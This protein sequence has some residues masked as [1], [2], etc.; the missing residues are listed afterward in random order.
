MST[1]NVQL[2]EGWSQFHGPNL[3]YVLEMYDLYTED[4]EA[5]DGELRQFFEKW[6]APSGKDEQEKPSQ[7]GGDVFAAVQAAKLAD[8]IR[9]NGHLIADISPVEDRRS[10]ELFKLENYQLSEEA[11]KAIPAELLTPDAPGSVKNGLDAVNHLKKVYSSALAFEFNQVHDLEERQWLFK[12]VESEEY[13]PAFTEEMRKD[14]LSRLNHVEGFEHFLHKTFVGQKRFSI[15]GLDA[16]V[17]ML[18]D[19]VKESVQ[20]G[21]KN[22]MIGMAHRGRLNV[23][24]HV[25]GKPYDIIFSEFVDAPNKDLVPS[26]GSVGINYGWTGDVKYHLGADREIEEQE[27]TATVTLANNPSHLEFVNPVVEGFARAVQDDRSSAGYP[28]H[29]QS[30]AMAILIHGD[31]AF[32]GQGIVAETLNLSQLTGY[33]T[34]GTIHV[35]ANNKIGFTTSSHDSR[36]TN[37]A[38]DL[39]K[40]FEVP[41]IHVNADHPEACVAA[42]HLA[43]EYRKRFSKDVLIDLI[44]YRRYGHNEMD[45]PAATQPKLYKNI[46][47]HKTA[48]ELYSE[49]LQEKGIIGENEGKEMRQK[50]LD[51]LQNKYE[52]IKT[53]KRESIGEMNPPEQVVKRLDNIETGVDRETLS[54]INDELLKFPEEFNVFPKLKKI[55]QRRERAFEGEGAIDWALGETLAFATILHDGKPIRL[56]GQDSERGTFSQRHLVL[57]DH[58]TSEKYSPLHRMHHANAS[59]AIHNSPLS[60]AAVVGFEYGYT[61]HAPETLTIWEAQYGDF[62]NGAQVIFDQFVAAGRAKWGQKSGLVLLLPHGYEGQGPEHSSGRAERFLQLAAENNWHVANVTSAAQYFHLLRRQ[63][64]ILGKDEVRP[65]VVMTPKSLLRNSN[66][67]SKADELASG[68]FQPILEQQG[69]AENP[70]NVK[71]IV[72]TTGKLAIDLAEAAEDLEDK[73]TVHVVRV[74]EIYPFPKEQVKTLKEKYPNVTEWVW[75]QEEPSNMGAWHYVLPNLK[76]L[77]DDGVDVLY[78][79]RRRRSAPAEGDPKAHKKDQQKIIEDALS[80]N[81]EG[82]EE[83]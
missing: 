57:H 80:V 67:I 59:F 70:E 18:D 9:R 29:D 31:A 30:K 27:D 45:E 3:G 51:D 83:E 20:D 10:E 37:Y 14:L 5:V 22:V 55:L 16:M 63:A 49:R 12:M 6:G 35:I 1:S 48:Y 7:G 75:A 78:I 73:D 11:L 4:P 28:E 40:G 43:Y 58:E 52:E 60:E 61:V 32:P 26:E 46:R 17:P 66:V 42:M 15:E 54:Q 23:L 74:E 24:A 72:F 8:D 38:S 62:S 69:L 2:D 47:A 33:A 50:L 65:L 41:V 64:S 44:G 39:A 82:R 53:N 13:R 19:A 56:T 81:S 34:G 71:R 77:A 21:A 25:L 36:S 68:S 79:G 76:E